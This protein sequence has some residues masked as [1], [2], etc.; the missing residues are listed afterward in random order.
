MLLPGGNPGALAPPLD[1]CS[2]RLQRNTVNLVMESFM[3]PLK[4]GDRFRIDLNDVDPHLIAIVHMK[5][6]TAE[7]S[8]T[9]EDAHGRKLGSIVRLTPPIYAELT[10]RLRA[11][12]V[13]S[14]SIRFSADC[15]KAPSTVGRPDAPR[16]PP[17]P[18]G[19]F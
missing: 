6:G 7:V 12:G 17:R 3:E 2:R 1:T 14:S 18:P 5:D 16:D 4:D 9:K 19:V 10:D 13:D 11:L 15:P 8:F